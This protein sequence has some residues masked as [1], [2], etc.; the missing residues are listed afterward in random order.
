MEL[1]DSAKKSG[2]QE[3][4]DAS[5]ENSSPHL[6]SNPNAVELVYRAGRTYLDGV[7]RVRI[8]VVMVS[9][10]LRV[11]PPVG[12]GKKLFGIHAFVRII[13]VTHTYGKRIRAGYLAAS[14]GGQTLQVAYF[15]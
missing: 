2:K 6:C 13:G 7:S 3:S 14:L 1:K 10:L 5:D 4:A 8:Q 12:F 15:V 11:H 9:S